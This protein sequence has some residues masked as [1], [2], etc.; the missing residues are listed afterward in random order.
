[1]YNYS[2][3]KA[4]LVLLRGWAKKKEDYS[5]LV[6]LLT[7]KYTVYPLDL[8]DDA[9]AYRLADFVQKVEDFLKLK[10]IQKLILVGHS[11]GGRVAIKLAVNRPELISKLVLIDSAGIER[12]NSLI[13]VL[14][15]IKIRSEFLRK[16]FGSKDYL[17]ARGNLRQTLVNVVNENLELELSKIKAP[18]LII[19]GKDDHTTPLWMGKVMATQIPGS[20]LT[21]V[22]GGNHGIPYR[23]ATEVAKIIC[24]KF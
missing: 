2:M 17:A 18:T 11:F 8:L 9:K 5:E 22:P 3:A 21:V 14:G 23:M 24:S 1:M 13:K 20:T 6:A 7:K 12:K 10:K 15:R 16:I 4:S 19:W